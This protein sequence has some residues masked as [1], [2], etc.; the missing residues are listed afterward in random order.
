MSWWFCWVMEHAGSWSMPGQVTSQGQL[1][2]IPFWLFSL[3][4]APPET[5]WKLDDLSMDPGNYFGKLATSGEVQREF[6]SGSD[7]NDDLP[8]AI[9]IA[10]FHAF[11][12]GKTWKNLENRVVLIRE[13]ERG[14]SKK[15][16]NVLDTKPYIWETFGRH[17][18]AGKEYQNMIA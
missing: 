15:K 3:G 11:F 1:S 9:N 6:V 18:C 2:L 14:W 17:A 10:H 8:T 16:Q 13:R 5:H 12:L 4:F 7:Q